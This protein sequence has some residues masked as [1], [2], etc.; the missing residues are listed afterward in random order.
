[1]NGTSS[2]GA[3]PPHDVSLGIAANWPQFSLLMATNAFVGGMAGLERAIVPIMGQKIFGLDSKFVILSFIATFG[4]SKAF[5][6]LAVGPLINRFS[7]KQLLISGW[8]VGIPVPFLLIWADSW[9]VVLFAN[10]LLGL[11]QGLTWSMTVNM[12]IDMAGPK[13]R[14][15]ALGL[16][17]TA[18]YLAVAASAFSAGLIADHYGLRPEPFY[19]GIGMASAGLALSVLFIKDTERFVKT[20]LALFPQSA[21]SNPVKKPGIATKNLT[22]EKL[23]V[24]QAG[25]MNN[26]NDALVWGIVPLYLVT[27]N[28]TL[29]EIA[30]VAA[31]YPLVWGSLQT[32]TGW[33]SDAVG[34]KPLIVVGMFIQGL[35]I[36]SFSVVHSYGLFLTAA[37][38]LGAG[39][40]MVYPVL[41][42]AIGDNST[43][44]SRSSALG[45][46]RFWRDIGFTG[47]AIGA[48]II[49]DLFGFT[50][51]INAVGAL[52]I[53]SGWVA[54]WLM[55]DHAEIAANRKIG[56]ASTGETL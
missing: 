21:L 43:P 51:A 23:A 4:L 19:L 20:E 24:T 46:Y 17:E 34:R 32:F 40:A 54:Y 50:A 7:R 26:F 47:G 22:A 48:G 8:L 38:I 25:F 53:L 14:G 52:T 56:A 45:R 29:E 2:P 41:M 27:R 28:L 30:A 13:Q 44:S 10:L 37:C 18:G 31:M 5:A 16:N 36:I 49:T 9:S 42:A 35:A 6:N 11:N 15:L 12:K 33:I 3:N 55:K 39:T 1:M